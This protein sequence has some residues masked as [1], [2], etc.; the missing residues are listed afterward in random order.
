[1]KFLKSVLASALVATSLLLPLAPKAEANDDT[2]YASMQRG[3]MRINIQV[4]DCINILN[5]AKRDL[6]EITGGRYGDDIPSYSISNSAG[7]THCYMENII[8]T[9]VTSNKIFGDYL[10][11]ALDAV[12]NNRD[13]DTALI[14]FEKAAEVSKNVSELKKATRGAYASMVAKNLKIKGSSPDVIYD[15][16]RAITGSPF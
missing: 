5:L 14:N 3:F 8:D 13:Y 7:I 15:S 6:M 10:R 2:Y 1:M 16:W 4:S 9:D 12:H 11:I